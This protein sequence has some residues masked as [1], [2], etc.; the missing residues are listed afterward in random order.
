MPASE[1]VLSSSGAESTFDKT[2]FNETGVVN[3]TR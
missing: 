2:F 3:D 1:L